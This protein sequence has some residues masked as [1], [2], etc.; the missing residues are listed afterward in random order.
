[1]IWVSRGVDHKELV[2][3]V[4]SFNPRPEE[5]PAQIGADGG[6]G[7]RAC[8]VASSPGDGS[9]IIDGGRCHREVGVGDCHACIRTATGF[10]AATA[11]V[12]GAITSV[13]QLIGP[14]GTDPTIG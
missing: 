12:G 8:A 14:R 4:G 13:E 5:H 2:G 9:G 10:G 7:C 3:A 1:M 6:A 11:C